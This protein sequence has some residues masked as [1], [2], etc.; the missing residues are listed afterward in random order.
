MCYVP[1]D[2]KCMWDQ[3]WTQVEWV[4]ITH[5]I[6]RPQIAYKVV[7]VDA[8]NAKG[9]SLGSQQFTHLVDVLCA[10]LW[11]MLVRPI[12]DPNRISFTHS[13]D[14][15]TIVHK[16]IV[17]LDTLN[18]KGKIWDHNIFHNP[19]HSLLM[20]Y[21]LVGGKCW[22]DQWWTLMKW[23]L[24]IYK[25]SRSQLYHYGRRHI[26][27][28]RKNLGPQHFTQFANLWCVD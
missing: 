2:G 17:V 16:V 14:Y 7:V 24:T 26:K 21:M 22:W 28:K 23:V 6:P 12:V 20:Y 27:Y 11:K 15:M 10:G 8:L 1:I 19:L 13:Q 5:K 9:K 4:L 18:A 25:M 3:W